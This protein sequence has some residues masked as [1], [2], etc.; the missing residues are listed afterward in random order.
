MRLMQA[1]VLAGLALCVMAMTADTAHA[2]Q[3]RYYIANDDHTD[4]FWTGTDEDYRA[5]FQSML[6]YYMDLAEQTADLPEDHRSRF[7][8]DGSLWIY[9]YMNNRSEA[10]TERLFEHIRAGNIS[11]PMQSLV[12]LPGAMPTEAVLRDMYFAGRL[13]RQH[14]L[15]IELV[16][17]MENQTLPAGVASLWAGSGARY[18]WKGV[19]GCVSRLQLEGVR[20]DR[21]IYRFVGP[22][23]QS[24][25]MKWNS[26]FGINENI[27]GYAEARD[28]YESVRFMSEDPT[29]ADAWPWDVAGAFGHGWDD[30]FTTTDVFVNAAQDLSNEDRRVIV[31]NQVDFFEDFVEHHGH[32]LEDFSGSFGNEWDLY[33]AS[34]AAPTAQVRRSVEKLRS[35]EAIAAIAALGDP[36]LL[37]VREGERDRAF[38]NMGLYYEHDWTANS[39]L[40]IE[41]RE[42]FQRETADQ[43]FGYVENFY[44]DALGSL[45]SQISDIG[46]PGVGFMVFNP[47]SWVRTEVAMLP[48]EGDDPV[49]VIDPLTMNEVPSQRVETEQGPMLAV[50]ATEIPSVGYKALRLV[51][52]E[53]A[54]GEPS[55]TVEDG[56]IEN[57]LYRITV[58]NDGS[59]TSVIDRCHGDREMVQPGQALGRLGAP[60][61]GQLTVEA[62]GP[63]LTTVRIDV[64]SEPAHTTRITIYRDI[65]RIDMDNVIT[66]N[67]GDTVGYD[68]AFNMDEDFALRHEEV[69]MIATAR[70]RSAG[71]DYADNHARTDYLTFNHFASFAQEGYAITLSNADS[72]FMRVGEST[73][74][75]LDTDTPSIMAVVG[76]Q[77]DGNDLGFRDQGGDS[78]FVNRYSVRSHATYDAGAAMR[79]SLAHQ[80]P[81][82]A[83]RIPVG[84]EGSLPDD[85]YSLLRVDAS[86]VLAFSV[87]PADEGIEE[88]VMVRLWNLFGGARTFE[89]DMPGA[90][91]SDVTHTSHI[92]TDIAPIDL[93]GQILTDTLSRQEM[94][95][96]RLLING[97]V[98]P[99]GDEGNGN[100]EADQGNMDAQD[101]VEDEPVQDVE[102]DDANDPQDTGDDAE[103][104]P[105]EDVGEPQDVQPDVEDEPTED[106]NEPEDVQPDVEDE[107]SEDV[108]E[109]EDAQPDT[110]DEPVQ[111]VEE[112]QDMGAPMD[113]D[114]EEDT[115][116]P[117]GQTQDTGDEQ[118]TTPEEDVSEPQDAGPDVDD[119]EDAIDLSDVAQD[120]FDDL[121]ADLPPEQ[122]IGDPDTQDPRDMNNGMGEDD[123][124]DDEN[125][126]IGTVDIDAGNGQ[127]EDGSQNNDGCQCTTPARPAGKTPWGHWGTV[128]LVALALWRRRVMR[129]S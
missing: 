58:A 97:L 79:F 129:A 53:P 21:E 30:L 61:S 64:P 104:E 41:T 122:D 121:C 3:T 103:D 107:P 18:S 81:L 42:D 94:K 106:A 22:D 128:A 98:D 2:Q 17:M 38:L 13:E 24:V 20:R 118:D 111:D 55:A 110:E 95:T 65:N 77:V 14:G 31:S 92:E 83:A 82:I 105:T 5:A 74:D 116:E 46:G 44:S 39:G 100:G 84:N 36:E 47:L 75:T 27:G 96:Y 54:Q 93:E 66:E 26:L 108:V 56:V 8:C 29:F 117:D 60:V 7:N 88:G 90:G 23:G 19:C 78:R 11:V 115:Q 112:P 4:Y 124:M 16:V 59:I 43:I 45:T 114:D 126:S 71:G 63:V 91:L 99:G 86:E 123:G 72:S 15:D 50:L 9:E 28:P 32:E 6:D 49:K 67:F 37:S 125:N 113:V 76:M 35:A 87:K 57:D 51:P 70:R 80:N 89:L 101:D 68:F 10:E 120:T 62:Q 85:Q 119:E 25:I 40:A 52:G 102:D 1:A 127:G 48:L 33:T 69:G 34:L 73:T 109:P 12:L